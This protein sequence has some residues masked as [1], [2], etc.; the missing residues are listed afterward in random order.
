MWVMLRVMT[1]AL[2]KNGCALGVEV[3][4]RDSPA[5]LGGVCRPLG[6][7]G[8][9]RVLGRRRLIDR[10]RESRPGV[11]KVACRRDAG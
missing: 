6:P 4:G 3:P 7:R 1:E 2:G 11:P 10:R 9:T 8:A 5:R